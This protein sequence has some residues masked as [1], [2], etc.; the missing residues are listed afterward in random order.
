MSQSYDY[1]DSQYWSGS[2]SPVLVD[3]ELSKFMGLENFHKVDNMTISTMSNILGWWAIYMKE[4]NLLKGTTAISNKVMNKLFKND[5]SAM[6]I[7]SD[8]SFQ[9]VMINGLVNRHV[10]KDVNLTLTAQMKTDLHLDLERLREKRRNL[11]LLT[12]TQV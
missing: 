2:R 5:Y 7:K 10:N 9:Y 6:G 4:K 1:N 3:R 8:Q 12:R 11:I